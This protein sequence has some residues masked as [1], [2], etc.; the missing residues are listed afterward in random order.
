MGGMCGRGLSA[1]GQIRP[2]RVAI[3]PRR[4]RAASFWGQ[5]PTVFG[6]WRANDSQVRTVGI[7]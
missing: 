6:V 2:A 3:R 1:L 4:I 7:Q 5:I